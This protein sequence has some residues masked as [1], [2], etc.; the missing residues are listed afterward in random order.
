MI[1]PGTEEEEGSFQA[2]CGL[3]V[4]QESGQEGAL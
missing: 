3:D 1:F 4:A 2:D